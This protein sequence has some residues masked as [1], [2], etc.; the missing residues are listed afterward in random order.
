LKNNQLNS[1]PSEISK[2]TNLKILFL[3]DN[4]LK[5]IP[6]TV[7][8]LPQLEAISLG[9]NARLEVPPARMIKH[10]F[11]LESPESTRDIMRYLRDL[12][13]AATISLDHISN[14][15]ETTAHTSTVSSVEC[16]TLVRKKFSLRKLSRSMSSTAAKNPLQSLPNILQQA[17]S[18]ANLAKKQTAEQQ[19]KHEREIK[20]SRKQSKITA[21]G[22]T[23]KM[24]QERENFQDQM[25]KQKE[26][27][28]EQLNQQKVLFEAKLQR[29]QDATAQKLAKVAS[30]R[31]QEQ[32]AADIKFSKLDKEFQQF[33][34]NDLQGC[35]KEEL[36]VLLQ[37]HKKAAERIEDAVERVTKFEIS[38]TKGADCET[39]R[40]GQ[41][42]PGVSRIPKDPCLNSLRSQG[43]V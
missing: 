17:V 15:P 9:G 36:K 5:V 3:N 43:S 7:G 32:E 25:A 2:L 37:R 42:V 20:K 28:E 41:A 27:F 19:H 40:R 34:G 22:L 30:D 26:S 38:L 21:T 8:L 31:K 18:L 16:G 12:L 11:D 14:E 24:K 6:P 29:E 39:R 4:R 33:L 1:L 13:P 35:N 10:P 23:E